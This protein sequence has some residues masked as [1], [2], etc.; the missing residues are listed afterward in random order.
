ML[1]RGEDNDDADISEPERAASARTSQ[2]SRRS[3]DARNEIATK[4][5]VLVLYGD[6]RAGE[7]AGFLSGG[8]LA[9][10]TVWPSL[11]NG[12]RASS[13]VTWSAIVSLSLV[14]PSF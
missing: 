12:Q 14:R 6:R 4:L 13:A 9:T 5:R 3:P 1:R 10:R 8:A 7:A 11:G 2:S